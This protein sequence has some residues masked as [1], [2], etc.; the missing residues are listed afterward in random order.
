MARR[1]VARLQFLTVGCAADK[2]A[3]PPGRN[4]ARRGRPTS[5]CFDAARAAASARGSHLQFLREQALQVFWS[6]TA[7]VS[8]LVM[9]FILTRE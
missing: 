2:K 8:L 6:V 5:P 3:D 1:L 7:I 4:S 9:I